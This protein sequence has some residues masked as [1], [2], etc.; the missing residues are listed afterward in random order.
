MDHLIFN[1]FWQVGGGVGLFLLGMKNMSDGMQAA[2]GKK[3]RALIAAATGH[4]IIAC[5]IGFL[6]TALIQSSSV[7]TVMLVGFANA[8]LMTL[9]QAIGVIL[10]ADIGT[11][12]TGWILVLDIG[13]AGLPMLGFA[14]LFYLF[15]RKEHLRSIA[16]LIIGLGMVF[17]GLELMKEG[18]YPL[19]EMPEFLEWFSKFRPDSLW[20]LIKCIFAGA[21]VTAVI[22]SS[23]ATV[24][25]TMSL[26]IAGVIDFETAVA[27]VLGQ[28]IG[29]TITAF[30]A[31]LGATR[32]AKRVAYAH[33]FIKIIGV[34]I[35]LGIFPWYLATIK[36]LLSGDPNAVEMIRGE[37]VYPAMIKGIAVAHTTFN[38]FLVIFF[39][40][41]TKIIATALT[42][43]FPDSDTEEIPHLTYF[44][45]STPAL[46]LEQSR[47]ELLFMADSDRRMMDSLRTCMFVEKLDEETRRW[48]FKREEILDNVQREI[49]EFLGILLG[50]ETV[51][52]RISVEARKQIRMADEYETISDYI[53]GILKMQLKIRENKLV[54]TQ[55]GIDEIMT[56]HDRTAKYL[57]F[58]TAAFQAQP[59]TDFLAEAIRRSDDLTRMMREFRARHLER[60]VAGEVAPQLSLVLPDMLNS[61]RRLKDHALN[62]AEIIAGQK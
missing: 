26:A 7:T 25:I 2:A 60:L 36:L 5:M 19:R 49:T 40:P 1:V 59:G 17:F 61:Y 10:G 39:L 6:V 50:E 43:L 31:S 15:L 32:T 38:I 53:T 62:I 29:T 12:V 45:Q 3:L 16:L 4:R 37:A 13:K 55:D 21:A 24:G 23:S 54:P 18:F 47:Q 27:L 58:V 46:S 11:T 56:L 51:T 42:R 34:I 30:L 35:I 33:I 48:I 57:D 44:E 52:Y 9:T 22:Q 41:F 14:A 28:N 20:G 8:G